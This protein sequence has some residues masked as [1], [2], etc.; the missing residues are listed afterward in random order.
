M[1][2]MGGQIPKLPQ[3]THML[4]PH[5]ST[6]PTKNSNSDIVELLQRGEK[7]FIVNR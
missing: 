7:L 4:S 2:S 3:R 5:L 1:W 6:L